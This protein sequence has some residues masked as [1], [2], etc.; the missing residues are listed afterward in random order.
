MYIPSPPTNDTSLTYTTSSDPVQPLSDD[1]PGL[2]FILDS[3]PKVLLL[4]AAPEVLLLDA[5]PLGP[6]EV[7][8]YGS[9]ISLVDVPELDWAVPE[10]PTIRAPE[11]DTVQPSDDLLFD[12]YVFHYPRSPADADEPFKPVAPTDDVPPVW[13]WKDPKL[14]LIRI[15]LKKGRLPAYIGVGSLREI[16]ILALRGCCVVTMVATVLDM[17][18]LCPAILWYAWRVYQEHRRR[19]RHLV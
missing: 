5:A 1:L 17:L 18:V 12:I 3:M 15:L 4:D 19:R 8:S 10:T 13:K 9:S 16:L 6:S 2:D 11:A 7:Y 14:L